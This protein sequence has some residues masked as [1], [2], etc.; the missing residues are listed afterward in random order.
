MSRIGKLPIQLPKGVTVNIDGNEVMVK[1]TRG[2]MTQRFHPDM[3]ISA[4]NGI[5]SVDRP[6]DARH[7]RALHGRVRR[8]GRRGLR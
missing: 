3:M 8:G 7:H 4:E 1:G 2:S 5:I 6:T